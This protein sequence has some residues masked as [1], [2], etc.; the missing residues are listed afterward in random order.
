M[1][2][3]GTGTGIMADLAR[4][5]SLGLATSLQNLGTAV[6]RNV[7]NM[8][9]KFDELTQE[10]TGRTIAE[11][12]DGLKRVVDSAFRAIGNAIDRATPV[13]KGFVN[14][15]KDLLPDVNTRAPVISGLMPAYAAY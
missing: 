2:E 6:S 3:L 8:I 14:V 7:A 11:N 12:I 4:E 15:V 5:N 9:T 1:I 13:V 10:I